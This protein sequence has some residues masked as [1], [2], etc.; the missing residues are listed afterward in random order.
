MGDIFSAADIIYGLLFTAASVM[1][2]FAYRELQYA[3]WLLTKRYRSKGLSVRFRG[4]NYVTTRWLQ[5]RA[6]RR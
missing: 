6:A 2:A 4:Q 5:E 1:V 3:K